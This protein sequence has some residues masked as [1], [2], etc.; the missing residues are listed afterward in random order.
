MAR[1]LIIDDD[2]EI[3]SLLIEVLTRDKHEVESAGE[4]V[5]GMQ[6]AR[7]F[8]PELIILDYHMPGA[9]GA[10]LYESLRRNQASLT[11][12]ILFMSG[13]ASAEDILKE[14]ADPAG[15][16]FL[17]KP[18]HLEDFRNKVKEMLASTSAA[19]Q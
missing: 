6:K 7:A 9:T 10:H 19:D 17:A 16:D 3:V 5:E 18:V 13:E 8:R 1:I 4:P 12:P 2:F 15:A 14:I 11:T